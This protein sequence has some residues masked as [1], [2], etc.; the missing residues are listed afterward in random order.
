MSFERL[1]FVAERTLL[2]SGREALFAVRLSE[3]PGRSAAFAKKSST[4]I[5]SPNSATA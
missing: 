1:Q 2:G 5:A 4:A 3:Q